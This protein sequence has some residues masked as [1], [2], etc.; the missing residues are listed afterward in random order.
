MDAQDRTR[1]DLSIVPKSDHRRTAE[2]W[3]TLHW[4][5]PSVE[6]ETNWATGETYPTV[7]QT[8]ADK[9]GVIPAPPVIPVE[10]R[11]ATAEPVDLDSVA[12]GQLRMY[13]GRDGVRQILE[14]RRDAAIRQDRTVGIYD[15]T[16]LA[17][18]VAAMI[19]ELEPPKLT[20]GQRAHGAAV[21]LLQTLQRV[22]AERESLAAHLRN[23]EEAGDRATVEHLRG[24]LSVIDPT[25]V[26]V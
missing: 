19:D 25:T 7:V 4:S 6:L 16:A 1:A 17:A 12:E 14:S 2:R 18:T 3:Y 22:P 20:P 11:L 10:Q 13:G 26:E 5:Y 21:R 15:W 23:T 8:L 24:L 9:A